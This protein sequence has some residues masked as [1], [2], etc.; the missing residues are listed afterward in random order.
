MRVPFLLSVEVPTR[1]LLNGNAFPG[2]QAGRVR[3]P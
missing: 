2:P 1:F 3:L